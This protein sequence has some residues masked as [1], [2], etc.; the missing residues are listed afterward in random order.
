MFV[1]YLLSLI[2]KYFLKKKILKYII[3]NIINKTTFSE[4]YHFIFKFHTSNNTFFIIII[5]YYKH[6]YTM[7]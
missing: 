3:N 7:L 1:Y 2:I 6:K 5:D 4:I